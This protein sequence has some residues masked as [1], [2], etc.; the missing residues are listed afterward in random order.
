MKTEPSALD[1]EEVLTAAQLPALPHSAIRLLQIS[2]DA[3][4]GPAELAAPIESDV[5]LASQVLRFVNSSYF[6]F[7]REV[8]SI[9]SAVMLV[10]MRT[11]K[12]F[13]LWSAVFSKVLDPKCGRFQLK[14]LWEDSL[15][16]ALFARDLI[17]L[18]GSKAAD[19]AFAAALLQDMAIPLLAKG[20]PALYARLL[21]ARDRDGTRLSALE[22]EAFGWTHAEAAKRMAQHWS[23]P[24]EFAVVVGSHL[25]I[26]R[27]AAEG[28]SHPAE[29]A[30]AMSALLPSGADRIWLECGSLEDY[31]ERV[32]PADGPALAT[33]LGQIDDEF[34]ELAPL[35]KTGNP[36]ISLVNR[37]QEATDP[38]FS[39]VLNP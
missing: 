13:V 3:D 2:K 24:E 11:I 8:S 29:L 36:R 26:E 12:N 14:Q 9:K 33:L 32:V 38:A 25:E 18:F 28:A 39:L 15:R 16:R 4:A 19:N 35:M 6:G 37:Y 20:A 10:G 34:R 1:L 31:Y 7:S 5:G 30:V 22:H 21:E 27:W 17:M 23:L